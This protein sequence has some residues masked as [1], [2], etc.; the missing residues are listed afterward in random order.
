[1]RVVYY[2]R[3]STEEEGQLNAI[4][5]QIQMLEDFINGN[6][7]WQLVGSYID[8][9]KSGTTTKGRKAYNQ[10]NNDLS[11][12][13][14]DIVVAKDL[15]RLNRN[16]SD[17]Y[18][19]IDN[20]VKNK[21]KLFLYI[22]NK[23]YESDDSLI[24]GIKA[25][26]ASEY[27][28]DL[29]KKVNAGHKQR[30]KEGI[31]I[32]NNSTWG[33]RQERGSKKLT[34]DVAE[35]E[36]VTKIFN[37]YIEG[38]GFRLIYKLLEEEGIKNR[39]GN[40]FAIT[41]LKRIIQNEKYKGTLICNKTHKD[42]DTKEIC[43]NPINEWITHV[44]V[45][46]PIVSEEIWDQA[47]EVLKTKKRKN[48]VNDKEVISGYFAGTQL[49]SG[50]ILCG[51]CGGTF[52]HTIY[53]KNRLW[54]CREY[55]SFGLKKEGKPHGC[56]NVKLYTT[57]LN[58]M[59]KHVIFDFI[60]NKD[61]AIKNVMSVLNLSLLD[62][63]DCKDLDK[64]KNEVD[65]LQNRKNKIIDMMADGLITKE[66]Y[67]NRKK[68][69]EEKI[70]KLESEVIVINQFKIDTKAKTERLKDIE[71]IL[72]IQ[73]ESEEGV[74]EEMIKKFLNKIIVKDKNELDIYINGFKY[75][76]HDNQCVTT[77]GQNRFIYISKLLAL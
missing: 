1:M 47:N 50:K 59:V 15:S 3:V 73:L 51:Q 77:T 25:I 48:N 44:N 62:N 53:R 5:N 30:Q 14:F 38:K 20:L 52:W 55:K 7:E 45:I 16:P 66:E 10:L 2:A 40:P 58:K 42:F 63:N 60:Q 39:N 49:Y 46:S 8:S 61:T 12:D 6:L 32:T 11:T 21:K 36:I 69:V 22:D 37:W 13:K 28:R 17:Y 4:E 74:T 68:S 72:N 65:K 41:T 54:M 70:E 18:K 67:I 34:I 19:F 27:S 9:G 57:D 31:V 35:A 43:N 64:A 26:L 29:S 33:Y 56:W 75:N 24:N 76:V 71:H 23:F